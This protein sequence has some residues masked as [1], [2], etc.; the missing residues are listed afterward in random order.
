MEF[1]FNDTVRLQ[2]LGPNNMFDASET[3]NVDEYRSYKPISSRQ[4]LTAGPLP[5]IS[6]HHRRQYP[7]AKPRA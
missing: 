6:N 5:K 7:E 3:S 1:I 2:I 4:A